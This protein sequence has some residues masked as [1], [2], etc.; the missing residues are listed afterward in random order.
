VQAA[1]QRV[2]APT[3]SEIN[4]LPAGRR[5]H[6]TLVPF[7]S[8]RHSKIHVRNDWMELRKISSEPTV[9]SRALE[10]KGRNDWSIKVCF[11][12]L[13]RPFPQITHES[14]HANTDS[15]HNSA[16]LK[17]VA[18]T[19]V[20]KLRSPR[21]R[22]NALKRGVTVIAIFAADTSQQGLRPGTNTLPSVTKQ[23]CHDLLQW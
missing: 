23:Q 2:R 20:R 17:P 6:S 7:T 12:G 4:C 18:A 19:D 16:N 10:I 13:I 11:A 8:G 15:P 14:W 21:M 1:D 9:P 3:R 5:R 22:F